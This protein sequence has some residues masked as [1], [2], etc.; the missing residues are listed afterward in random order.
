MPCFYLFP[1]IHITYTIN[2]T[3]QVIQITTTKLPNE[4][5]YLSYLSLVIL[6]LFI[7]CKKRE[8]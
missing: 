6:I 1:I 3:T 8:Q 5:I 4:K 7:S 2:K